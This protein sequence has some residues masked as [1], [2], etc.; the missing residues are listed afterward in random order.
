MT[1]DS[2]DWPTLVLCNADAEFEVVSPPALVD[3]LRAWAE[4]AERAVSRHGPR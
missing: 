1:S 3:H 4:R 2:L